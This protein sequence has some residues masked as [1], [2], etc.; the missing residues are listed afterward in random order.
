MT[1]AGLPIKII[2]GRLGTTHDIV[3]NKRKELGLTKPKPKREPRPAL[4][5]ASIGLSMTP[6]DPSSERVREMRVRAMARLGNSYD[7]A[8]EPRQE[9]QGI[10]YTEMPR[11][12]ACRWPLGLVMEKSTHAC[13]APCEGTYCARHRVLVY[14]EAY[15]NERLKN[16]LRHR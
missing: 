11:H 12:G 13:G 9:G 5:Y 2:A 7:G 15:S 6:V 8:F 16:L 14:R 1:D 4:K 10:P 3:Y